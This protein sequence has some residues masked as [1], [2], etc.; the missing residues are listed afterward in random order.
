MYAVLSDF[1]LNIYIYIYK[2]VL[3]LI[4]IIY[5]RIVY[6]QTTI[7]IESIKYTFY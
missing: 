1:S 6:A 7:I 4:I 2:T 3:N 5:L